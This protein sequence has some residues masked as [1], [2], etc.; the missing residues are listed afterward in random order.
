WRS[1]CFSFFLFLFTFLS[2]FKPRDLQKVTVSSNFKRNAKKKYKKSISRTKILTRFDCGGSYEIRV[3][4]L[5]QKKKLIEIFSPETIYRG[6]TH[7]FHKYG[8]GVRYIRFTH[9]G[10]NLRWWKGHFGIHITGSSV[11]LFPTLDT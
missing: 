7:V 5:D 10:K 3:E 4:L 2:C 6:I 9:G 11:E 8:P 1:Y